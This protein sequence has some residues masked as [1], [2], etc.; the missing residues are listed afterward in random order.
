MWLMWHLPNKKCYVIDTFKR[1]QMSGDTV[2]GPELGSGH[3][4][5]PEYVEFYF[6]PL[7][8]TR[9][10]GHSLIVLGFFPKQVFLSSFKYSGRRSIQIKLKTI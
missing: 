4:H 1:I 5:F 2:T 6:I 3:C 9:K 7:N 10:S 8:Q